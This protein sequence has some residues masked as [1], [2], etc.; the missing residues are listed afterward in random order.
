MALEKGML[1]DKKGN[2]HLERMTGLKPIA[3]LLLAGELHWKCM[4]PDLGKF[5]LGMGDWD[6]DHSN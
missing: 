3:G 1:M 5:N 6:M 4:D 2:L